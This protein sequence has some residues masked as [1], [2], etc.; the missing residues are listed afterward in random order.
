MR[1]SADPQRANV[2]PNIYLIVPSIDAELYA[3]ISMFCLNGYLFQGGG[4]VLLPSGSVAYFPA[5][6]LWLSWAINYSTQVLRRPRHFAH[7]TSLPPYFKFCKRKQRVRCTISNTY[8][9]PY[10]NGFR[11]P[12][13]RKNFTAFDCLPSSLPHCEKSFC[14]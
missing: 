8:I 4:D 5:P 11:C 13:H 9:Y 14:L 2:L 10:R 12:L 7:Q 1:T 6:C 3:E